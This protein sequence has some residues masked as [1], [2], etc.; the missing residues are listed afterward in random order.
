MWKRSVYE[1]GYKYGGI[2]WTGQDIA[3][4]KS[5]EITEKYPYLSNDPTFKK[6]D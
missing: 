6:K 4:Y 3:W 5:K 2:D 1:R